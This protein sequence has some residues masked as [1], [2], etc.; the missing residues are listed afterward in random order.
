MNLKGFAHALCWLMVYTLDNSRKISTLNLLLP[1]SSETRV[2]YIIEAFNGCYRFSSSDPTI[3]SV[4]SLDSFGSDTKGCSNRAK[5]RVETDIPYRVITWITATEENTGIIL[6]CEARVAVINRLDVITRLRTIDVGNLETVEVMGFDHLGNSFSSLEGLKFQWKITQTDLLAEFVSYRNSGFQASFKR[7]KIEDLNSQSDQI[8]IRGQKTGKIQLSAL[9]TDSK[10]ESVRTE[11]DLFIIEH[12]II[13]PDGKLTL[14]KCS[15]S[16]V[17]FFRLIGEKDKRM[18]EAIIHPENRF[19]ATIEPQNIIEVKDNFELKANQ[20]LGR[21]LLTITDIKNPENLNSLEIFISEPESFDFAIKH[22]KG[23]SWNSWIDSFKYSEKSRFFENP[24]DFSFNDGWT[25]IEGNVYIIKPSLKSINGSEFNLEFEDLDWKVDLNS[26][27]II[28]NENFFII[29][30]AKKAGTADIE[31]TIKPKGCRTSPLAASKSLAIHTKIQI[32]VPR[33]EKNEAYLPGIFSTGAAQ[34]LT[35]QAVGGSGSYIWEAEDLTIVTISNGNDLIVGNNGRTIIRCRDAL[36]RFNEEEFVLI[37]EEISKLNVFEKRKEGEVDTNIVLFFQALGVSGNPFA[38]VTLTNIT[39]TVER[40]SLLEYSE[41]VIG[42][43]SEFGYTIDTQT[44][45]LKVRDDFIRSHILNTRIEFSN[46]IF[47]NPWFKELTYTNNIGFD[48]AQKEHLANSIFD[49]KASSILGAIKF[50]SQNSGSFAIYIVAASLPVEIIQVRVYDPF[51]IKYPDDY[52]QVLFSDIP[53]ISFGNSIKIVIKGGPRAWDK[54]REPSTAATL[55]NS[56]NIAQ[57]TIDNIA[58]DIEVNLICKSEE[59]L[60]ADF[61]ASKSNDFKREILLFISSS[62]EASQELLFPVVAKSSFTFICGQPSKV[63]IFQINDKNY[64]N[65]KFLK[66]HKEKLLVRNEKAYYFVNWNFDKNLLPY[67][68]F[69]SSNNKYSIESEKPLPYDYFKPLDLLLLQNEGSGNI[70]IDNLNENVIRSI[71]NHGVSFYELQLNANTGLIKLHTELKKW[72][73]FANDTIQVL[74]TKKLAIEPKSI[75]LLFTTENEGHLKILNGSGNFRVWAED[76][77]IVITNIQ[78]SSNLIRLHPLLKGKTKIWVEDLGLETPLRTY[79]DVEILGYESLS[80]SLDKKQIPK[81]ETIQAIVSGIKIL[82]EQLSNAN[83][84]ISTSP[85]TGITII[86]QDSTVFNITAEE[87]GEFNIIAEIDGHV[88]GRSALLIVYP[89]LKIFPDKVITMPECDTFFK[90]IGGPS[91]LFSNDY[92]ITISGAEHIGSLI[93]VN[94]GVYKLTA[95]KGSK[96]GRLVALVKANNSGNIEPHLIAKAETIVEIVFPD[97]LVVQGPHQLLHGASAFLQIYPSNKGRVFSV[98]FCELSFNIDTVSTGLKNTDKVVSIT[99]ISPPQEKSSTPFL[100]QIKAESVGQE[101]VNIQLLHTSS[102]PQN[103]HIIPQQTNYTISVYE[104]VEIPNITFLDD[105]NNSCKPIYGNGMILMPPGGIIE[106]PSHITASVIQHDRVVTLKDDFKLLSGQNLG[107]DSVILQ[108]NESKAKSGLVVR[109][110]NPSHIVFENIQKIAFLHPNSVT[111]VSLRYMDA[112]GRLFTHPLSFFPADIIVSD[113]NIVDASYNSRNGKL[114]LHSKSNGRA[115]L[116]IQSPLYPKLTF[117]ITLVVGAM[118][119]PQGNIIVHTGAEV[120]LKSLQESPE[121]ASLLSLN[122]SIITQEKWSSSNPATIFVDP[123]TGLCK[124][125]RAGNVTVTFKSA[126]NPKVEIQS[127]EISAITHSPLNPTFISNIP[128]N[129]NFKNKYIFKFYPVFTPSVQKLTRSPLINQNLFY[130]CT[131]NSKSLFAK[132]I[133]S[134]DEEFVC[135]VGFIS[136]KGDIPSNIQLTLS[137]WSS[138]SS[139]KI[140]DSINI[141]GITAFHYSLPENRIQLNADENTKNLDIKTPNKLLITPDA[142]LRSFVKSNFFA[143]NS[144]QRLYV[145]VDEDFKESVK[146]KVEVLNE[147]SGQKQIIN[148]VYEPKRSFWSGFSLSFSTGSELSFSDL[149]VIFICIMV[150]AF[151]IKEIKQK[152]TTDDDR[153]YNTISRMSNSRSLNYSTPRNPF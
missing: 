17:R 151:I 12:I 39:S 82:K 49:Y 88:I 21:T 81:G 79:A 90:L 73:H 4:T 101:R 55:S 125:Q 89:P 119:L 59:L 138:S 58:N 85:S 50:R 69:T 2:E 48:E 150:L 5:V 131:V 3:F 27:E 97:A 140:E 56:T 99:Q 46:F 128:N 109:V 10:F 7:Q 133:I 153:E 145:H 74:S 52:D 142:A 76:S 70:K 105:K 41:S 144:T 77:S 112:F 83:I 78:T 16:K 93:M 103:N 8:V 22:I 11:V 137:I 113:P 117:S 95:D 102:N 33:N 51:S 123:L 57:V 31:V 43:I 118:L 120:Q 65:Y 29:V 139:F 130:N 23:D 129:Q 121:I 134:D 127:V 94:P 147:L 35:L 32:I 135:E 126:I 143:S 87:E 62:N 106:L 91:D 111:S 25:A 40:Q 66:N 86:K 13:R 28:K 148:I 114:T 136:Q 75:K 38:N 1:V 42:Q 24:H 146:G 36:N 15:G 18:S 132:Q 63:R 80:V 19:K 68:N 107:F 44:S 92:S 110:E 61:S 98:S 71:S 149:L 20:S 115:L 45:D 47:D 9:H 141:S 67:Y 122:T 100:L 84:K 104:N 96:I 6:R 72:N 30:K 53:L 37:I 14:L 54:G 124:S 64:K 108:E 60:P 152:K 26:F 116:Y 34:H